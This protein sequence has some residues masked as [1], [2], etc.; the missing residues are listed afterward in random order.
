MVR[1]RR[2]R[3]A[4]SLHSHRSVITSLLSP[5]EG[6]DELLTRRTASAAPSSTAPCNGH[7]SGVLTSPLKSAAHQSISYPVWRRTFRRFRASLLR[8]RRRDLSISYPVWQRTFRR[9]K[10]SLLRRCRRAAESMGL[11]HL[12]KLGRIPCS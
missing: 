2:K 4:S 8:R 12:I 6:Y 10:A 11:H 1:K 3:D 7:G 9:L 5:F